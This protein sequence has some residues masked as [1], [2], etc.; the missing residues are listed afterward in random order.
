MMDISDVEYF[1]PGARPIAR[2]VS[3]QSS[4]NEINYLPAA[5]GVQIK[6]VKEPPISVPVSSRESI[7]I[8]IFS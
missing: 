6:E 7:T 1:D 4:D 3:S 5:S 2:D 8:S